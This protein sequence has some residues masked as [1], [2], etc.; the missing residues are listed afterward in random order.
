[1]RRLFLDSICLNQ[2][3]RRPK[4]RFAVLSLFVTKSK[5]KKATEI[6]SLIYLK[7]RLLEVRQRCVQNG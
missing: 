7:K 3:K 4:G 2:S 6:V 1:M 5:N